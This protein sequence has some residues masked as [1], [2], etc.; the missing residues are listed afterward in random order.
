MNIGR[1]LE[2]KEKDMGGKRRERGGSLG[3]IEEMLKRK[4]E[5]VEETEEG[6]IFKVNRKTLRLP[7]KGKGSEGGD[8]RD[9]E[10]IERRNGGGYEGTKG[11]K[12]LEGGF[13]K[14]EGGSER[15][16]K[17]VEKRVEKG[18]EGGEE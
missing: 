2:L 7:G 15:S 18:V 10:E 16:D 6:E 1:M 9:D 4:R 17:G 8:R 11:C 5:M 3:N 14:N 13:E 12:G